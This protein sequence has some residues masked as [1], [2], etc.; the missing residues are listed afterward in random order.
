MSRRGAGAVTAGRIMPREVVASMA[1]AALL[2]AGPEPAWAYIGPGAGISMIGTVLA[3]LGAIVL[4]ITGL[5]WYSEAKPTGEGSGFVT[6]A[7]VM[8]FER[9]TP[10]ST[11]RAGTSR[12]DEV[13]PGATLLS[14]S[15]YAAIVD[16]PEFAA[17]PLAPIA[18]KGKREP[19]R[20]YAIHANAAAPAAAARTA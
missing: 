7:T 9:G 3:L 2:L 12:P 5:L 14:A 8:P 19:V 6:R 15:S 16:R 20:V 17:E 11:R 13:V 1:L 10:P 4:A 18:V